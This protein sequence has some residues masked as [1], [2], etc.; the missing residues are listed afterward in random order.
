MRF[1]RK[2]IFKIKSVVIQKRAF[3]NGCPCTYTVYLKI[4]YILLIRIN[5]AFSYSTQGLTAYATRNSFKVKSGKGKHAYN[6]FEC[7]KCAAKKGLWCMHIRHQTNIPLHIHDKNQLLFLGTTMFQC[8]LAG[9]HSSCLF[10]RYG[11]K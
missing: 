6:T 5:I 1:S 3:H 10:P 4:N 8:L 11:T 2:V 7:L 9:K